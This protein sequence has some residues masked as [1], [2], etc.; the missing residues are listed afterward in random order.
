MESNEAPTPNHDAIA[1]RAYEIYEARGGDH[2][3]DKE[4]WVMAE[5]ELTD[6][7]SEA[8]EYAKVIPL[9]GESDPPADD[10]DEAIA[11]GDQDSA[12]E[13]EARGEE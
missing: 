8:P 4:D 1:R 13:A 9:A 12:A 10:N 11:K 3:Y 7:D 6:A 2:G 5:Q